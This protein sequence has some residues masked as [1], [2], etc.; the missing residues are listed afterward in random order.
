VN[1]GGAAT[2][3]DLASPGATL[4]ELDAWLDGRPVARA[5]RL[6]L[7]S[8]DASRYRPVQVRWW[9][10]RLA[11]PEPSALVAE[12]LDRALGEGADA[13]AEPGRGGE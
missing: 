6:R 7:R 9:A 2:G 1:A 5:D 11:E 8:A 3:L 12:S 10:V 4:G 13:G